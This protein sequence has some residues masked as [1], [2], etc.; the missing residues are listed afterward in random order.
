VGHLARSGVRDHAH[1]A[2]LVVPAEADRDDVWRAVGTQRGERRE[3]A[4]GE[5]GE[6]G[7][8]ERGSRAM[9]ARLATP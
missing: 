9:P 7:T 4:L 5:K 8:R 6:L 3:V 1:E 2:G